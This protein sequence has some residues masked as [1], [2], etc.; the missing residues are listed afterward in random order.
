MRALCR[1]WV[2][3]ALVAFLLFVLFLYENDQSREVLLLK[4]SIVIQKKTAEAVQQE[5]S[6]PSRSPSVSGVS[7]PEPATIA[8]TGIE[9]KQLKL[10]DGKK[11]RGSTNARATETDISKDQQENK[12]Q[13]RDERVD[14][15]PVAGITSGGKNHPVIIEAA[16]AALV[17][18]RVRPQNTDAKTKIMREESSKPLF[19][20]T[21]PHRVLESYIAQHS[22]EVLQSEPLEVL[23]RRQFLLA[24]YN[25][26]HQAG[27]IMAIV[28]NI[29]LTA[30]LTNRTLVMLYREPGR[31]QQRLYQQL[32]IS[33]N[34]EEECGRVLNRASWI[35]TLQQVRRLMEPGISESKLAS[36]YIDL[37]DSANDTMP[38]NMRSRFCYQERGKVFCPPQKAQEIA[39]VDGAVLQKQRFVLLQGLFSCGG[40]LSD[41]RQTF[42]TRLNLTDPACLDFIRVLLLSSSKAPSVRR[43][44]EQRATDLMERGIV[45]LYGFLM[46][47]IFPLTSDL[48]D[49]LSVQKP[50]WRHSRSSFSMGIHL[51]Q[52]GN[53][54]DTSRDEVQDACQQVLLGF[55]K[56]AKG[57]TC[58]A[59][60]MG[61]QPKA[62]ELTQQ[63]V[64]KWG[65]KG[66]SMHGNDQH[67]RQ[68]DRGRVKSEHGPFA[69]A[70]FYQDLA[71][72]SRGTRNVFL[73]KSRSSSV[74]VLEAIVYQKAKDHFERTKNV[75][76]PSLTWCSPN[77]QD[78]REVPTS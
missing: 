31:K 37:Y 20:N 12:N 41:A 68:L 43:Q 3:T 52:P 78:C 58:Q 5:G 73:A 38:Y 26:P 61:D 62:V 33:A 16:D 15:I 67:R 75:H 49:S 66:F 51:R 53:V 70:G 27:N 23:Q 64:T 2:A 25:C 4:G 42:V 40:I 11:N 21:K 19:R 24:D 14:S 29:V 17:G 39:P 22:Q 71:L 55:N 7:A 65:C 32:N 30:V 8:A 77:C 45:F 6:V 74:L 35:P 47:K 50:L 34:S 10:M 59:F 44:F 69:G 18:T 9:S 46:E 57:G 1:G 63:R 54:S 76:S 13:K 56:Q 72:L 36:T 28:L 48:L 60:I